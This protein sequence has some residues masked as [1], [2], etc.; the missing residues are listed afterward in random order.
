MFLHYAQQQKI[1]Y[2]A[3][4]KPLNMETSL[5]V[6]YTRL[7]I[8]FIERHRDFRYFVLNFSDLEGN[9]FIHHAVILT[10]VIV[11]GVLFCIV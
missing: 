5:S 9:L 8:L 2:I 7:S 10:Y 4:I 6:S 1:L 3:Q 11:S